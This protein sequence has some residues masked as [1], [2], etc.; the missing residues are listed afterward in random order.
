MLQWKQ[1]AMMKHTL[2]LLVALTV[3]V[4]AGCERQTP[5]KPDDAYDAE[6]SV[7]A[8]ALVTDI[9]PELAEDQVE[10]ARDAKNRLAAAQAGGVD[11]GVPLKPEGETEEV[12]GGEGLKPPAGEGGPPAATQPATA[13]A[14]SQPAEEP[15]EKKEYPDEFKVSGPD[16]PAERPPASGADKS[17]KTPEKAPAPARTDW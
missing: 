3:L 5:R 8:N 1:G 11:A 4:G 15:A 17:E 13:P 9:N 10:I 7:P 2:I 6:E 12:P 14:A 16:A